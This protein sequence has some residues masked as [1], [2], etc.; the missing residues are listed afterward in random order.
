MQATGEE[1]MS[2]TLPSAGLCILQHMTIM[3]N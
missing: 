2:M 1:K 3:G